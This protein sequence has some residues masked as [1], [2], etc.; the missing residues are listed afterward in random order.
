[1][2]S[3]CTSSVS[4]VSRGGRFS[5]APGTRPGR[6]G[7]RPV[8]RSSSL[9]RRHR[10]GLNRGC[11]RHGSLLTG[12]V[13]TPA[14]GTREAT[15][16]GPLQESECRLGDRGL[17]GTVT[18]SALSKLGAGVALASSRNASPA[19]RRAFMLVRAERAARHAACSPPERQDLHGE[20]A[21]ALCTEAW[22]IGHRASLTTPFV[23]EVRLGAAAPVAIRR[24]DVFAQ[25]VSDSAL[26]GIASSARRSRSC[27]GGRPSVV[28]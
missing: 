1:V 27:S 7:C 20:L 21:P 19:P 12:A 24:S 9:A 23:T 14:L 8:R 2:G 18:N 22:R 13:A 10:R 11:G 6:G 3:A 28:R 5:S 25:S 16:R 15:F 26:M 17:T 4:S